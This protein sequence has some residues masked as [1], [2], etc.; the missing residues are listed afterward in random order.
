MTHARFFAALLT[1]FVLASPLFAQETSVDP[2][3]APTRQLREAFLQ[4]PGLSGVTLEV[5]GG[6]AVLRGKVP[7][8]EQSLEAANLAQKIDGILAVD[9]GIQVETGLKESLSPALT[10][11]Y[12]KGRTILSYLPLVAVAILIFMVVMGLAKLFLRWNWLFAKFSDSVF[13]QDLLK[14]VIYFVFLV[15]GSLMALELL[16]ATALVG[17][18][19]GT[20]GVL[21]VAVGFAFQDLAENSLAS[22]LLSLRQPFSPNDHVVING[23]EGKVVRLTSRATILLTLDGNHLRIP[24]AAV[25]KAIIL[26]YTRN[27][28]RRFTFMVGVDTEE[29]LANAQKVVIET[30]RR[31]PG[32][33]D[34]PK[35]NCLVDTLG[36]ST[37]QL[38]VIGWVDQRENDFIKTKSEIIRRVKEAL[39][40]AGIVMPEPIYKIR[41]EQLAAKAEVK[42]T[43]PK[44]SEEPM[45]DLKPETHLE[46]RIDEEREHEE[47]DLLAQS[48][49][50]E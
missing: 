26:N 47:D 46:K 28:E 45:V 3:L 24:N 38:K 21:G 27:P 29:E 13:V 41:M 42:K 7:S 23:E 6:V 31:S 32:V 37:V 10:K 14:Q 43:T 8:L 12:Q 11:F 17:A 44:T 19:L 36:D 22:V 2:D 20:A 18:V 30:L 4:V 34:D 49:K 33:M 48:G 50:I 5:R 15:I 39:D 16:N 35:P 40:D 25:F 9:N 1:L